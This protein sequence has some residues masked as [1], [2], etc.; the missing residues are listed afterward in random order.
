MFG[1]IVSD[2]LWI[3]S[4]SRPQSALCC[5]GPSFPLSPPIHRL[6]AQLLGAMA[7]PTDIHQKLGPHAPSLKM[8]QLLSFHTECTKIVPMISSHLGFTLS[9]SPTHPLHHHHF[10]L[11]CLCLADPMSSRV[12][13]KRSGFD[14]WK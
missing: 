6:Q 8:P 14:Y 4:R 9:N 1:R 11:F 7:L 10:F 3:F 2:L 13:D 5:D 12:R